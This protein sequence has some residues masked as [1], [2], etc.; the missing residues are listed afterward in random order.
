MSNDVDPD[1]YTI[2]LADGSEV[3]VIEFQTEATLS[4]GKKVQVE[5]FEPIDDRATITVAKPEGM[6]A[7]DWTAVVMHNARYARDVCE[8]N[9]ARRYEEHVRKAAFGDE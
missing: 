5:Q 2:T 8:T 3:S 6:S 4:A 7:E 9:V 1:A